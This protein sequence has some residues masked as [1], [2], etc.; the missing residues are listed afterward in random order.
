MY[1]LGEYDQIVRMALRHADRLEHL[2]TARFTSAEAERAFGAADSGTE[3]KV[4]IDW[5]T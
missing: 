3:G 2:V 1:G 4:V 5:T